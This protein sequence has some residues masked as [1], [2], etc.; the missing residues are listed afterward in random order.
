MK[1]R[2]AMALTLALFGCLGSGLAAAQDRAFFFS[3]SALTPGQEVPVAGLPDPTAEDTGSNAWGIGRISFRSNFTRATIRVTFT[4]LSGAFTRLHLHCDITGGQENGPVVL[5]LVDL[6]PTDDGSANPNDNTG[7]FQLTSNMV[8][9]F[10]RNNQ[11]TKSDNPCGVSDLESLAAAIDNGFIYY[12]L[13][14][15]AF[16]AGEMRG[17]V[18]PVNAGVDGSGSGSTDSGANG[19]GGGYAG[20]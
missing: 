19:G 14:T 5:G 15:S 17:L 4:N 8:N 7:T 2:N 20:D 18:A 12:N 13:H 3:R 9:G 16:P 6:I 11:V 10:F 1:Q